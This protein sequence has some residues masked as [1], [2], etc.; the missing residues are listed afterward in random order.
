MIGSNRNRL[1]KPSNSKLRQ[2]MPASRQLEALQVLSLVLILL[3]PR[4]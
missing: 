4:R 2:L 3:S 1:I